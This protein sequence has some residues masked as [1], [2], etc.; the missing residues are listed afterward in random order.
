MMRALIVEDEKPAQ[1]SLIRA[2]ERN[3][4]DV[5][6]VGVTESVKDTLHWLRMP[7]NAADII[8]LDVE[9]QD[10]S[11]FEVLKQEPVKAKVI[12]TTAFDKYAVKAF[13][14]GSVDYLLK[15]YDDNDL[16]RAVERCRVPS[17]EEG[18]QALLAAMRILEH[19]KSEQFRRR[20]IIRLGQQIIPV[21]TSD[22]AYF[23]I[24]GKD[25]YIVMDSGTRYYM[26]RQTDAVLKELDPQLFFRISRNYIIAF[27]AIRK[28]EKLFDGR[29]RVILSPQPKEEVL[30]ARLRVQDFMD[31]L[32]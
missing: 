14:I 4:P 22:I 27:H 28:I 23:Y 11:S 8:F 26:D 17:Q 25:K 9:L 10:G 32:E 12:M 5:R 29:M 13:Q 19:S 31:W 2:L 18:Q 30:V 1:E 20:L 7:G 21:P 16:L 24:E 3:C 15:P 6:V